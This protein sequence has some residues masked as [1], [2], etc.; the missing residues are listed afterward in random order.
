[1]ENQVRVAGLKCDNKECDYQDDTI[2]YEEYKKYINAPCPKCGHNLLTRM[3][4]M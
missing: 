1:M 2:R 3:Y 4:I